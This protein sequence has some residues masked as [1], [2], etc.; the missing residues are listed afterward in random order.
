MSKIIDFIKKN[1]QEII[2]IGMIVLFLLG[3]INIKGLNLNDPKSESK[4]IKEVIVETFD[5]DENIQ[6]MMSSSAEIFCESYLDDSTSLETACNELTKSN[7][8]DVKCCVYGNGK[9]VSGDINGPTYKTDK[10]GKLLTMDTYYYLGNC[11][12]VCNV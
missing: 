8:G 2:I 1:T 6:K 7:C 11:R 5:S 9:C 4:L 12:G 3:L 10:D